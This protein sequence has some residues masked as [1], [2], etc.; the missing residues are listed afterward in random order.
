MEHT[1]NK[2]AI[3]GKLLKAANRACPFYAF[4]SNHGTRTII[5]GLPWSKMILFTFELFLPQ[6]KICYESQIKRKKSASGE[7]TLNFEIDLNG[8][9]YEISLKNTGSLDSLMV[10]RVREKTSQMMFPPN[11]GGKT[12]TYPLNFNPQ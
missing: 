4:G 6:F 9:P 10:D 5:G 2:V 1:K 7:V 11:V 12:V 8:S 3:D